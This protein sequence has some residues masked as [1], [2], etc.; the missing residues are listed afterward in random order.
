MSIVHRLKEG[1]S[2]CEFEKLGTGEM[3]TED[4]LIMLRLIEGIHDP[5][6]KHKLLETLQGVNLTVEI[7]RD[8]VQNNSPAFGK[9]C[10]ICK[11]KKICPKYA[12]NMTKDVQI[13]K[14]S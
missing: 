7:C 9:T 5:A 10:F 1:A 8:F 2:Y 3:I 12:P 14:K 13:Q 11:R 6:F 4:E